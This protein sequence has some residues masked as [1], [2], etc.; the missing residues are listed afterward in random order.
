MVEVSKKWLRASRA[1]FCAVS[2][3]YG[4]GGGANTVTEGV[5]IRSLQVTRFDVTRL[6]RIKINHVELSIR[7]QVANLPTIPPSNH[8]VRHSEIAGANM[9][10]TQL[11]SPH[12]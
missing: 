10:H 5:Q 3:K 4:H 11:P 1:R 2:Y 8:D 12:E 7:D 9:R 6:S